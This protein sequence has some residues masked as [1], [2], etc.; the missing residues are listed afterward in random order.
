MKLN[1]RLIARHALSGLLA[2][3]LADCAA[4]GVPF[5]ERA[6]PSRAASPGKAL[7]YVYR[8]G[9]VVGSGT[10]WDLYANRHYVTRITNGG[11]YDFEV[12]PGQIELGVTSAVQ[13]FGLVYSV[14]TNLSEGL[15]QL[16]TLR[17]EAGRTYYFRF[18][19]GNK[20][21]PVPKEEAVEAMVGMNRFE[22]PKSAPK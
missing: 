16:Y 4:S 15:Q 11:Y 5:N 9:G 14:L 8:K 2:L 3:F 18:E 13:P 20:M 10:S 17:A 21:I 6:A 19:V 7:V 1:I 22:D 12:D